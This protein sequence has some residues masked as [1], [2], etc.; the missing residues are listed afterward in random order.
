MS[1]V[2][3]VEGVRDHNICCSR[4]LIAG[5]SEQVWSCDE[6][7]C[8]IDLQ[9]FVFGGHGT[10]GWLTRYDVYYNDVFNLN[11]GWN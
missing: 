5:F 6:Q 1:V 3:N 4:S 7:F 11:R 8:V 10:A 9:L 2:K